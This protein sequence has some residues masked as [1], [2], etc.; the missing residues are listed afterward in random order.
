MVDVSDDSGGGV[1]GGGVGSR[2]DV[3]VER[4]VTVVVAATTV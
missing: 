2:R 4:D 1:G 3:A